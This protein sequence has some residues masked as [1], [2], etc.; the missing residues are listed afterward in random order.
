MESDIRDAF[1][2][3]SK[4]AQGKISFQYVS[5]AKE[6]N[7]VI[8][9]TASKKNLHNPTESGET[10]VSYATT[11]DAKR[12][13]QNPGDINGAKI[14][15]VLVDIDNKPWGPGGLRPVAMHEIG[16]SLGLMGH[17]T[18]DGDIMYTQKNSVS[19]PSARDVNTLFA[20]YKSVFSGH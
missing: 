17:S 7:V 18:D 9:W 14:T 6:A 8:A 20:L 1:E 12:T 4:I 15:F 5:T 10:T 3:W 19:E 13:L 2:T 11:G 16:H